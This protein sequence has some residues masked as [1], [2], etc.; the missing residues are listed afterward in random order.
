MTITKRLNSSEIYSA[1]KPP[2]HGRII[3][4]DCHPD[5]FTAAVFQGT[6][7][8]D[9][10]KLC[11][12][13]KMSLERLLKWAEEEFSP[14]DLFL[15]EAGSNSFEIHRQLL[16]LGR[17]AVVLES[18]WVGQRSKAYADNDKMAAARIALV[19]LAGDAPC[20]W[21]PDTRTDERRQLLHAHQAAVAGH[22]AA[23]NAIKGFLTQ[24]TIRLGGRGLHLER[25]R[26]W[27]LEKREWSQLQRE[28]LTMHFAQIDTEKE[29]RKRLVQLMAQQVAAEPLMLRC[30]KLMGI[31]YINAFALMAIIGD[32]RRFETPAK[33]VAYI[34]L[35]P[36]QRDSGTHKRVKIGVGRRGRGDLRRLLIQGAQGVLRKGMG[37]PIAKWG[38]RLFARK[39]N[40]NIA[41]AAVARKLVVQVWHLL[42]GNPPL[43]LEADRSLALKLQKLAV[44]LGK[45][46]R[47]EIGFPAAL[48]ECVEALRQR[49]LQ[50]CLT[51]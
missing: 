30:L 25:T 49:I 17:R 24:F 36:G 47:V 2:A 5:T 50:P 3:G 43:A 22:T 29:R 10:H 14:E 23:T 8:H 7:P 44:V 12:R 35:N 4:L 46:L 39:G 11:S 9:A 26:K 20:V 38:W 13:E 31:G 6:T 16:A 42:S 32:I 19:Y 40:R 45:A 15:M 34:G 27:I 1:P 51:N 41:V 21:V 48:K 18:C 37:I 28:L 33:L